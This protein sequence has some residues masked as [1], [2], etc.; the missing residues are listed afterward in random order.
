MNSQYYY[1]FRLAFSLQLDNHNHHTHIHDDIDL[2]NKNSIEKIDDNILRIDTNLS[3]K[4]SNENINL[5]A[6][7]IHVL[8][9]LI[10]S[11]GVLI[12]SAL[13]W[14]NENWRIADP[15]CTLIFSII[16]II[17]TIFISLDIIRILMEGNP[18]ILWSY[19]YLNS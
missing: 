2:E 15:I 11:L 18:V 16:V 4:P 5:R 1:L 10:Q 12:A 19:Y 6:A 13:I 8:G 7:L 9:D 14:Y 3:D 17:S